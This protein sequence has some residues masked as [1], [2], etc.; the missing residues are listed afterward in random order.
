M[1]TPK[2]QPMAKVAIIAKIQKRP[3]CDLRNAAAA[4]NHNPIKVEEGKRAD[5]ECAVPA[6]EM[7][8]NSVTHPTR[9]NHDLV[10]TVPVDAL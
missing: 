4:N 6:D 9:E 7:S 1:S 5:A 3:F 8:K 10:Y 2:G